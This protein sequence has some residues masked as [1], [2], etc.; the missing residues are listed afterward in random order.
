VCDAREALAVNLSP[1]TGSCADAPRASRPT[2]T[3][4]DAVTLP[5]VI[6]ID[7]RAPLDAVVDAFLAGREDLTGLGLY[8]LL[9]RS[10][11]LLEFHTMIREGERNR[12]ANGLQQSYGDHNRL[13]MLGLD[14]LVEGDLDWYRR[15]LDGAGD[16]SDESLVACFDAVAGLSLPREALVALWLGAALHDA[17]MLC[18]R[19][20]YVDVE[21]GVV[22]AR[23]LIDALCP[24]GLQ[25]LSEFVL[26][27]HDY[28]KSVFLGEVPTALVADALDALDPVLQPVASAGLG[29]V[30][31]AGAA[32]LGEGR[33][34]SF[35]IGIFER[36]FAGEALDD[37]SA[38]TRLAR[39]LATAPSATPPGLDDASAALDRVDPAVRAS[40]E[41][42]FE[43]A[44]LHAW[45]RVA[46]PLDSVD[47]MQLLAALAECWATS[48]AAHVALA[49]DDGSE[50]GARPL[51]SLEGRVDVALSG[52]RILTVEL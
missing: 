46:A 6:S 33:L 31:V 3:V 44:S 28:I 51:G 16:V 36:C 19:G 11:P 29:L 42:L 35:R 17:G 18:G 27:H 21:D 2:S 30:Q 38:L 32:S 24:D 12:E 10:T 47:R 5:P 15:R 25:D 22:L 39:L 49:L 34:G 48:D 50:V 7:D 8:Y 20:A 37:R 45:H 4:D 23:A 13:L 26:H 52:A 14:K 41:S 9:E 1:P 43:R 40:L